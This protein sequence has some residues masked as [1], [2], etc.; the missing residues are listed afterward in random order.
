MNWI[1]VGIVAL[2][3]LFLFNSTKHHLN[4]KLKRVLL[5]LAVFFVV[6]MVVSSYFDMSIFFGKG[7]LFAKTGAAVFSDM[8]EAVAGKDLVKDSTINSI[9]ETI[10]QKA[11][12]LADTKISLPMGYSI[13]KK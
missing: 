11:S 6:F 12:N 7:N 8:K 4:F 5:L 9:K 2:V 3:F 13:T 1:L 10:T